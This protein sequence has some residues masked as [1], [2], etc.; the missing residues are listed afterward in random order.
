MFQLGLALVY[1][2]CNIEDT[3]Y[4]ARSGIFFREA[5]RTAGLRYIASLLTPLLVFRL[6]SGVEWIC[7]NQFVSAVEVN[8]GKKEFMRANES[9]VGESAISSIVFHIADTA[10][11]VLACFV[12]A[13]LS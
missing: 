6:S 9:V 5:A 3:A 1:N 11:T 13:K 12:C 4:T 2:F 10:T 8:A 7:S